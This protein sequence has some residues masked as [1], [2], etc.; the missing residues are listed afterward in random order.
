MMVGFSKRLKRMGGF[1]IMSGVRITKR[2]AVWMFWVLMF[3][4]MFWIMWKWLV[5]AGWMLYYVCLGLAWVFKKPI[6]KYKEAS[7]KGKANVLYIVAG[8]FV[9]SALPPLVAGEWATF[10]VTL[11][12]AA[13]IAYRG[14]RHVKA[15]PPTVEGEEAPPK[16][17]LQ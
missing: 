14:Y 7:P 12:I 9:L 1:S 15:T 8:V 17:P 16:D 4:G 13:Y 5:L 2:N 3:L 6:Q 10:V 11:L